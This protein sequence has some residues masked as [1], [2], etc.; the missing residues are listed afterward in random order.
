MTHCTHTH[1]I[2]PYTEAS[3]VGFLGAHNPR[4]ASSE[5]KVWLHQELLSDVLVI[6]NGFE[7]NDDLRP[8]SGSGPCRLPPRR[9]LI[10]AREEKS[11]SNSNMIKLVKLFRNLVYMSRVRILFVI[12][13]P[14]PRG[15]QR[16][17]S[18][19]DQYR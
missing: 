1:T 10:R 7:L 2:R 17:T 13:K 6:W 19:D 15:P 12:L 18:G 8:G 4:E 3:F 16:R 9:S 11:M 5:M 14:R